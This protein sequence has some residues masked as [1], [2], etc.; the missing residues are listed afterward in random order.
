MVDSVAGTAEPVNQMTINHDYYHSIGF[1][2]E[3]GRVYIIM[4]KNNGRA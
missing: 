2:I 3:C 4:H 1:H